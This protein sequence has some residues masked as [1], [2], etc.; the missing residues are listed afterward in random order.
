MSIEE[1]YQYL[2]EPDR[3]QETYIVRLS[4]RY[5]SE[6]FELVTNEIISPDPFSPT[7]WTWENDWYEGQEHVE[8]LGFI[9]LQEV[10][11]VYYG[12]KNKR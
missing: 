12:T 9:P 6:L 3:L 11:V 4:L 10:K 8:V 5:E 2:N 7:R 1:L